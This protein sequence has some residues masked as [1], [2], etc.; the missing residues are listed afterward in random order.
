MSAVTDPFWNISVLNLST[1][2]TVEE[3][4]FTVEVKS[5]PVNVNTFVVMASCA[6]HTTLPLASTIK[7]SP[8]FPACNCVK[9]KVPPIFCKLNLASLIS[10][11]VVFKTAPL[12]SV[13]TIFSFPVKSFAC[14]AVSKFTD[15]LPSAS[16]SKPLPGFT[17]PATSLV[18]VG[19]SNV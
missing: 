9:F 4:P 10:K 17:T 7:T 16:I 6:D 13:T 18:A 19:T 5:E 12:P 1:K 11:L 15:K 14:N 2:L 8:A 3:T